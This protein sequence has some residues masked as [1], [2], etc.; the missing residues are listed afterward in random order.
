[1]KF[2][3]HSVKSVEEKEGKSYFIFCIIWNPIKLE[4]VTECDNNENQ[5][6]TL[7]LLQV[8]NAESS[9]LPYTPTKK[10]N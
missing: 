8:K 9:L 4:R 1:M 7:A 5:R 2:P 3:M 10:I 6:K